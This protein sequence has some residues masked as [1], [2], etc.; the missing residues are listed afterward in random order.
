MSQTVEKN[1]L[2]KWRNDRKMNLDEACEHF[3]ARG[4]KVSTAKLSRMERDQ[5]V[6]LKMLPKVVEITEIPAA[7]LRPDLVELG[8]LMEAAQ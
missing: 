8:F 2:R 5:A 1:P 4:C 3:A 7:K 6:P